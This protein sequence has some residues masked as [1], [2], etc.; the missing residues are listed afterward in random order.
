MLED[1]FNQS[2]VKQIKHHSTFHITYDDAELMRVQAGILDR[3]DPLISVPQTTELGCDALRDYVE[4]CSKCVLGNVV[5]AG[6]LFKH[7]SH[8]N[9]REYRFQQ[10]FQRDRPA[11]A[12][13]IHCAV[14]R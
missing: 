8:R 1:D 14:R 12:V 6:M 13:K 4:T 11:P 9:E 10:L 5:L 3:L 2:K 7:E